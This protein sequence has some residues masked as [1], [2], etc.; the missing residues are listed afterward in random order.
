VFALLRGRKEG[1]LIGFFAGLLFDLFYGYSGIVGFYSLIYMFMGY[2]SGFFHEIIYTDDI[3]IPVI[4]TAV[5]D[6]MSNFMFYIIAFALRNKLEFGAY[7]S[8]IILPEIIYTV[9][10]S[11]FLYRLY[12]FINDKLEQHEKKQEAKY[13]TRDI[14][15]VL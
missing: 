9:F 8:S 7:F 1:L 12:K 6:F 5:C 2:F 14:G 3:L 4:F 15:N 13:G 10:L 11:V